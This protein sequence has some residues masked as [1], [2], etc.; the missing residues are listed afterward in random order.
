MDIR[1]VGTPSHGAGRPEKEENESTRKARKRVVPT[2]DHRMARDAY[3]DRL[4]Q[5]ET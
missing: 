4:C 1:T 5:P 2:R 3:A